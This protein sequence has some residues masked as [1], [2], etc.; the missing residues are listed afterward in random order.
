MKPAFFIII[1]L[2]PLVLF[3]ASPLKVNLEKIYCVGEKSV[4]LSER[5]YLTE[6]SNGNAFIVD[7]KRHKVFKISPEGKILLEFGKKGAGPGDL[8]VPFHICMSGENQLI[9]LDARAISYFDLNGTFIKKVNLSKIA[10][11]LRRKYA[12]GSFI[13]AHRLNTGNVNLSPR[14]VLI[15]FKPEVKVVNDSLMTCSSQKNY[16]GEIVF[17]DSITPD[18]WFDYSNNRAVVASSEDYLVKMIDSEGRVKT[19]IEKKE[20]PLKLSKKE[21]DFIIKTEIDTWPNI[22]QAMKKGLIN[23]LPSKK[24]MITGILLSQRTIFVAK[25]RKDISDK[26]MPVPVDLYSITGD[27][28][29]QIHLDAFPIFASDKHFYFKK[30]TGDGEIIVSKFRY[31]VS[32]RELK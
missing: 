19:I 15:T 17:H 22:D 18:I 32:S 16:N 26:D 28:L 1:L 3:P 5:I 23:T 25:A 7:A 9:I 20:K 31:S 30:E 14:M 8:L 11:M 2:L 4:I 24:N 12:G 10:F 13:L 21:K 27:F 6:D 29:G